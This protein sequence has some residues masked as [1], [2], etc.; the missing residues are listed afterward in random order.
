MGGEVVFPTRYRHIDKLFLMAQVFSKLEK[1][2]MMVVPTR[3]QNIMITSIQ[4][5]N[6][7]RSMRS[8]VS[9]DSIGAGVSESVGG[10]GLGAVWR[11]PDIL[12]T[13]SDDMVRLGT[14]T[15]KVF[16]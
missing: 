4:M 13:S 10:R 3:K 12:G 6:P 15:F 5:T 9:S 14:E 8:S 16:I 1:T 2:F 11:G 7:H